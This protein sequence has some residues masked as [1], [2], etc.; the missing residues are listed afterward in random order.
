MT[1]TYRPRLSCLTISPPHP[2]GSAMDPI[3]EHALDELGRVWIRRSAAVGATAT[4]W[5][6]W[7]LDPTPFT[8]G[9]EPDKL[10][11]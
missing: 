3:Q 9:G 8:P 10:A 2:G 6:P 4:G 5:T 11:P 1:A 7:A